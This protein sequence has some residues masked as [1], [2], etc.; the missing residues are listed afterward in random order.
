MP[1][2]FLIQ[3]RE[4]Y[5]GFQFES[6]MKHIILFSRLFRTWTLCTEGI[7]ELIR[8]LNMPERFEKIQDKYGHY[9]FTVRNKKGILLGHSATYYASSSRD[10]AMKQLM[11]EASLAKIEESI[12]GE[13][14]LFAS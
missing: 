11:Q 2:R 8:T 7:N 14:Q 1:A 12:A 4:N 3:Q 10:Y 9:H 6:E 13:L 5:Y